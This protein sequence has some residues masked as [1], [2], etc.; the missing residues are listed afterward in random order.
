MDE[1]A[2][3]DLSKLPGCP[4]C[5][6]EPVLE[7]VAI[8]R[9]E[10]GI[11]WACRCPQGHMGIQGLK[12]C[13]T[14]EEAMESYWTWAR[15]DNKPTKSV[16]ESRADKAAKAARFFIEMEGKETPYSADQIKE[17]FQAIIDEGTFKSF[18]IAVSFIMRM[19][20]DG[21][22]Q[23]PGSMVQAKPHPKRT[24]EKPA[25]WVPPHIRK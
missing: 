14:P 11:K 19:I 23:A 16:E 18:Y 25:I 24:P 22:L 20:D 2:K 7:Q 12:L 15:P 3:I 6:M 21:H 4:R 17:K 1:Q 9:P 10:N 8:G 13:D 5:R